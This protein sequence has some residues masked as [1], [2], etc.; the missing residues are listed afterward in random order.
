MSNLFAIDILEN[1]KVNSSCHEVQ[2]A[3][4]TSRK[5]FEDPGQLV[6]PRFRSRVG[7]LITGYVK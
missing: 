4:Q 1:A 6:T 7:E 2:T 3:L 5:G